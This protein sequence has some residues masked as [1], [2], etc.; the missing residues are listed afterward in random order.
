M[1]R[2]T[3]RVDAEPVALLSARQER[4][5]RLLHDQLERASSFWLGFVQTSDPD[6]TAVLRER[7]RR[8]RRSVD[9]QFEWLEAADP[10]GL[11][12]LVDEL[13]DGGAP[14]GGCTWVSAPPESL[15]AGADAAAQQW[16]AGWS[17]LLQRLEAALPALRERLGGVLLVGPPDVLRAGG[18]LGPLWEERDLVIELPAAPPAATEDAATVREEALRLAEADPTELLGRHRDRAAELSVRAVRAGEHT[19]AAELLYARANAADLDDAEPDAAIDLVRYA[20]TLDGV[21]DS[22]RLALLQLGT[23]LATQL[24]DYGRAAD[25]ASQWVQLARANAERLD[26]PQRWQSLS[27][28]LSQL[29]RAE[30]ERGRHDAAR[31]PLVQAV[32]ID[33]RLADE[34]DTAEARRT[35]AVGLTDLGDIDLALGEPWTAGMNFAKA[36]EIN[37]RLVAEGATMVARSDLLHV[38]QRLAEANNEVGQHAAARDQLLRCVQLAE[39]LADE[40]GTWL[41]R[42]KLSVVLFEL[43]NVEQDLGDVQGAREHVTQSVILDEQLVGELGT[44]HSR[45]VLSSS[46]ARLGDL[47]F[48]AGEIGLARTRYA[49]C[50]ELDDARVDRRETPE[51][52]RK[53]AFD[54]ERLGDAEHALGELSGARGHYERAADLLGR[55]PGRDGQPRELEQLRLLTRVLRSLANVSDGAQADLIWARVLELDAELRR[56]ED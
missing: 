11:P 31:D 39:Q 29:G 3:D 53:L 56:L 18:G 36:L 9:E 15:P 41:T 43:A 10:Q 28:G 16:R 33:E 17:A 32:Q 25:W 21:D 42:G 27:N 47:E 5:W 26:T 8:C 48:G 7:T 6:A 54:L 49:R 12:D 34:L 13:L 14:P 37:E 52:L 45:A 38:L 46:L 2:V 23:I 20:L 19:T 24:A 40:D 50:V 4:S 22:R 55:L 1:S 35:L 51:G 30:A 44:W